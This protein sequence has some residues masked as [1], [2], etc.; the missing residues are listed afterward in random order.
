MAARKQVK[1]TPLIIFFLGT[2]LWASATTAEVTASAVDPEVIKTAVYAKTSLSGTTAMGSTYEDPAG[3]EL[4]GSLPA[5][6]FD[7]SEQDLS[8]LGVMAFGLVGLFWVRRHSSG[9]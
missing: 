5:T 9:L 2:A 3:G 6:P 4:E 8:T 1:S 7:Q